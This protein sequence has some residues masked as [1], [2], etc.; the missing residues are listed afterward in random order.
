MGTH[1]YSI[2]RSYNPESINT[3]NVEIDSRKAYTLFPGVIT[4]IGVA[5][6]RYVVSVQTNQDEVIRYGNI[7]TLASKICASYRIDEGKLIGSSNGNIVIEYCTTW[8]SGNNYSVH[9]NGRTYYKQNPV[10]II[11]DVYDVESFNKVTN[12]SNTG[13][14]THDF[15][16]YQESEFV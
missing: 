14:Y 3:S 15:D 10:D 12:F 5:N 6:G 9:I 7:S 11:E 2:V 13:M 8:S 16:S 1:K 4:Y